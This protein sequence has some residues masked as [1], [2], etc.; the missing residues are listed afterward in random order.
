MLIF[1]VHLLLLLYCR[2]NKIKH[3]LLLFSFQEI[4]RRRK[5]G[6]GLCFFTELPC[7]GKAALKR[8]IFNVQ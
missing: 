5:G 7:K 1:P 3:P 6:G 2:S 4:G 8:E